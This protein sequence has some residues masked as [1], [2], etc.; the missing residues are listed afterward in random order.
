MSVFKE[1]YSIERKKKDQF[2]HKT[3]WKNILQERTRSSKRVGKKSFMSKAAKKQ[4]LRLTG[5]EER[6]IGI[7]TSHGVV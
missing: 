6:A 4:T 1:Y 7:P 3:T 5:E 2:I